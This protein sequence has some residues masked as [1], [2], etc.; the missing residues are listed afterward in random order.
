MQP[1]CVAAE[2]TSNSF[3]FPKKQTTDYHGACFIKAIAEQRKKKNK[4][5][6]VDLEHLH[7]MHLQP[8]SN[9]LA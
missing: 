7:S 4:K 1:T 5:E 8:I 6:G 3:I 9:A 2:F